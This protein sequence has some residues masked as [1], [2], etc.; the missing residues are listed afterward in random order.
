[1]AAPPGK[2]QFGLD[3]NIA[4]AI[5]YGFG[6]IGGIVFLIIEKE[7]RYVRF[8]AMQS[9]MTFALVA[10][11]FLVVVGLPL[12]GPPLATLFL[13]GVVVLWIVL[14]IKAIS[15]QLYRLPYIG[16]WADHQLK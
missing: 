5:A 12:I 2:S 7:N 8:H 10:V 3:E 11:M 13:L 15:G 4:A 9:V 6:F 14:I 16:E 1:M